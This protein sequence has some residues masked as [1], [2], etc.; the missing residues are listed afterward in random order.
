[1]IKLQKSTPGNWSIDCEGNNLAITIDSTINTT[2]KALRASLYRN[3]ANHMVAIAK[4]SPQETLERVF[5]VRL[6]INHPQ[7][8]IDAVTEGKDISKLATL[9]TPQFVADHL[10]ST[11]Q[12]KET[13]K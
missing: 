11:V 4:N 8:R 5:I 10:K 1:M 12:V 3:L 2:S 9:S 7:L 13:P 6:R